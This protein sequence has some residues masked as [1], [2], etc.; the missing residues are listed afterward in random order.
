VIPFSS[1]FFDFFTGLPSRFFLLYFYHIGRWFFSFPPFGRREASL[2]SCD[3]RS[4]LVWHAIHLLNKIFPSFRTIFQASYVYL[5]VDPLPSLFDFFLQKAASRSVRDTSRD[6]SRVS[7]A[8]LMLL[9]GHRSVLLQLFLSR[10]LIPCLF[11]SIRAERFPVP[12]QTPLPH[13][14]FC[15]PVLAGVAPVFPSRVLTGRLLK[16]FMVVDQLTRSF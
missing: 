13:D 16:L 5:A 8:R 9:S 6:S 14:P 3:V 12:S 7:N 11:S 1:R 4:L 10:S 15:A 2:L